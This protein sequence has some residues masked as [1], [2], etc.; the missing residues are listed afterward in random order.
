[1]SVILSAVGLPFT[2]LRFSRA[3]A[4]TFSI[5][6]RGRVAGVDRNDL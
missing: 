1:L 6:R 2:F 4:G 3:A 5:L